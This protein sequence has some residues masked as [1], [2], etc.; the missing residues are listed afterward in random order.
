[1]IA[2]NPLYPVKLPA[3]DKRHPH[4]CDDRE[5]L[6]RLSPAF[7]VRVEAIGND[8]GWGYDGTM[9]RINALRRAGY[10]IHTGVG[11]AGFCARVT[12]TTWKHK[13][14]EVA[15]SYYDRVYGGGR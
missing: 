12:W 5:L 1:M 4:Y 8:M 9:R 14:R 10:D 15:E 7:P 6:I 3:P 13:A 11:D 2:P